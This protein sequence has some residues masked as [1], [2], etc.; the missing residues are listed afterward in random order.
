MDI[1]LSSLLWMKLILENVVYPR[2]KQVP[3]TVS[4][5]QARLQTGRLADA[6]SIRPKAGP[7]D[8]RV[9][10]LPGR[11]QGGRGQRPRYCTADT[12]VTDPSYT[13]KETRGEENEY[14]NSTK[15]VFSLPRSATVPRMVPSQL[16]GQAGGWAEA[17][18]D[19]P[20][21]SILL[22]L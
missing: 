5:L 14:G 19:T 4:P 21:F 22:A 11:S 2:S 15:V 6:S 1:K 18:L 3:P 8:C 9:C 13:W 17:G 20:G 7:A 12:G 16:C 10:R